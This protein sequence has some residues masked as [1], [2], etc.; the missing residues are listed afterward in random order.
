MT[1]CLHIN[2]I[3]K[4]RKIDLQYVERSIETL[5]DSFE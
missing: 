3:H 2:D 1:W 4:E 5:E